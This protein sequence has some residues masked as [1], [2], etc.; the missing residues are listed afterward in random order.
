MGVLF[1]SVFTPAIMHRITVA[2]TI[3]QLDGVLATTGRLKCIHLVDSKGDDDG[4][5][6]G[7]PHGDADATS[8]LLVKVRAA[9]SRIAP[10]T[11]QP[12]LAISQVKKNL[13]GDFPKEVDTILEKANKVEDDSS[14]I[15]KL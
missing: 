9:V 2:G 10:D 7:T 4:F 15:E 5:N 3:S 11:N 8:S 14:E 6:L 12:A 13:D 1:M